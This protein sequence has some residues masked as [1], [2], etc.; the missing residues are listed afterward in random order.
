MILKYDT[1]NKDVRKDFINTLYLK[2][3][4]IC[5]PEMSFHVVVD[6]LYYVLSGD[7]S[8]MPDT[9]PLRLDAGSSELSGRVELTIHNCPH[10]GKQVVIHVQEKECTTLEQLITALDKFVTTDD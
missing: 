10:C 1:F 8:H 2:S 6:H 5:C 9:W 4:E 3:I 7:P